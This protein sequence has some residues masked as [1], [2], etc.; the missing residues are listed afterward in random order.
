M[1]KILL[2]PSYQASNVFPTNPM[3]GETIS[4]MDREVFQV[5]LRVGQQFTLPGDQVG[6]TLEIF[7]IGNPIFWNRK[8]TTPIWVDLAGWDP[9]FA[10]SETS[11]Q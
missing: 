1:E 6:G 10:A 5:P 11:C 2:I 8:R 3:T 4:E 9:L 7:A